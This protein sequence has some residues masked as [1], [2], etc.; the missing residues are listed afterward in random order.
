MGSNLWA[1]CLKGAKLGFYVVN[2]LKDRLQLRWIPPPTGCC[3]ASH[4]ATSLGFNYAIEVKKI[5]RFDHRLIILLLHLTIV[6]WSL[7]QLRRL[8]L[9]ISECPIPPRT[10][11]VSLCTG[12]TP[13]GAAVTAVLPAAGLSFRVAHKGELIL[14]GKLMGGSESM[15]ETCKT[16]C[17]LEGPDWGSLAAVSL[18]KGQQASTSNNLWEVD[19]RDS[20]SL[21]VFKIYM[22]SKT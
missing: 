16:M 14:P 19:P 13:W 2:S 5:A 11:V 4:A 17:G 12:D 18:C 22:S 21:W 3:W 7:S 10:M 1:L 6:I 20:S 9:L 15:L 8:L